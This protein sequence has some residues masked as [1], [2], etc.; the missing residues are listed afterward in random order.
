MASKAKDF[1]T[2]SAIY[3]ILKTPT[4]YGKFQGCVT[5]FMYDH[6][7]GIKCYLMKIK[8]A[9]CMLIKR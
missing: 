4:R 1:L 3:L 7:C 5:Y 8:H 2:V 9:A 6:Y